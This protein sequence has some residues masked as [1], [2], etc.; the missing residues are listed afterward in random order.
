MLDNITT[1][2][3]TAFFEEKTKMPVALITRYEEHAT[4][5]LDSNNTI[6]TFYVTDDNCKCN[7]KEKLNNMKDLWLDF[8]NSKKPETGLGV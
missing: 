5:I 1:K 8:V 4:I 7:P 6:I 3:L 2:E